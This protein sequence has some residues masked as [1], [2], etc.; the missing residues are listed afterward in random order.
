MFELLG[1]GVGLFRA[2]VVGRQEI[3]KA[4]AT[5]KADLIQSQSD[6]DHEWETHAL[7]ERDN[8]LRRGCFLM[9]SLPFVW[10]AFDAQAVHDYFTVALGGVPVWY[11][12][13]FLIMVGSIWGAAEIKRLVRGFKK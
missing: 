9:F 7:D 6:N 4:K 8:V 1:A 13:S 2:W 10:A 5:K 11:V 12:K 3:V